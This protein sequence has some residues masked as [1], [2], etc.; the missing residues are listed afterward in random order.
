SRR[1]RE[2]KLQKLIESLDDQ[3]AERIASLQE[4]NK[5]IEEIEGNIA[6]FET[7]IES[8]QS[9]ISGNDKSITQHEQ[10]AKELASTILKL[11][12]ELRELY[13]D[14]VTQLDTKLTES[15]YSHQKRRNAEEALVS[16]LNSFVIH[17][18][19]R[20]KL[21]EDTKNVPSV[22]KNEQDKLLQSIIDFL[23][24]GAAKTR[25]LQ[26]FVEEFRQSVP[27]FIDDFLAPEG[28]I[29]RK[30]VIDRE[31]IENQERINDHRTQSDEIRKDNRHLS[32]RIEEYRKTLQ[33]L[34][35]ARVQMQ[36]QKSGV[37]GAIEL[38]Q[39]QRTDHNGQLAESRQEIKSSEDRMSG[40][41]KQII[42]L[43]EQKRALEGNAKKVEAEL[44]KLEKD[45]ASRNK[46][47]V[48]KERAQKTLV[49][50]LEKFHGQI[51]GLQVDLASIRTEVRNLY[52][53]F[54]ERHSRD[55][56]E[57]QDG[58][59]EI[60]APIGDFR[61]CL[62]DIR[63]KLRILGQVNLMAPEEYEEVKERF[64]FLTK[65]LSDLQKAK[66]DL[67]VVTEQIKTESAELFLD[68]YNKIKKNFHVMFRRLF[69][70]GR[71]EVSLTEPTK[72]LTSGINIQAQPPGKKL[73]GIDLLSGGEKSLTAV[74]LL[75]ATYMVKPSPFCV[76]D[77]ID[78]AL[79]EEN[80]GR[81]ANLLR[82][83]SNTSQ[84]IIITH[85]KRT[86]SAAQTLL[87]ITMEESGV[88]KAISV[89]I[90]TREEASA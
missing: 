10:Q 37:Q 50:N 7:N 35:V 31:I 66:D 49:L 74:A 28:I 11:Q 33:D 75:F 78:A 83:F 18:E 4:L 48:A 30:R 41:D 89:R 65:Q 85:N 34:R 9:R 73:E 8:A 38:L 21:L 25:E 68:T 61:A 72:I 39:T 90:G 63:E 22:K 24:E 12:E 56:K 17:M 52:E 16:A 54:S 40:I 36:S 47:L 76:L 3:I 60:S 19:G 29:T 2:K 82:E 44:S 86:V 64:D 6:S 27:A 77:E 71:A 55:L 32:K 46:E 42:S 23:S 70:G 1:E 58:I 43:S 81:F 57:F 13:D 20:S 14:I 51:E 5:R 45:I 67:K 53:N 15:G 79:D 26:G 80:V 69:G 62:S 84:F 88:S 87:G 59:L